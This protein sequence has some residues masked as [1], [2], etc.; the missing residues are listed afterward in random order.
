[1]PATSSSV[2][3]DDERSCG[4]STLRNRRPSGASVR[5]RGFRPAGRVGRPRH[6]SRTG[7]GCH[8]RSYRCVSETGGR[9]SDN[10]C[11][12]SS[13]AAGGR[14]PLQCFMR[15]AG[16]RLQMKAL[17]RAWKRLAGSL[18]GRRRE[19]ELADELRSNIEM[20]TGDNIRAGKSPAVARRADARCQ[21]GG[22][23]NSNQLGISRAD[24]RAFLLAEPGQGIGRSCGRMP[25]WLTR[26][27]RLQLRE[28]P[29]GAGSAGSAAGRS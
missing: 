11:Y 3:W 10:G 15:C 28:W 19:A 14:K 12:V 18:T 4:L 25:F 22:S 5:R 24:E 2:R 6:P 1:M 23:G 8:P 20:L 29:P 27:M 17:L 7:S 26:F 13:R 21:V 9:G 16:G